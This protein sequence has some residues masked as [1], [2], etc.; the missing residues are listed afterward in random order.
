[1]P[2]PR[3]QLAAIYD[4]AGDAYAGWRRYE[5]LSAALALPALRSASL[6]GKVSSSEVSRPVEAIAES[7]GDWNETCALIA[8]GLGILREITRRM[9]A[10]KGKTTDVKSE[11]RAARCDGVVGED[12]TCTN[13]AVRW[14]SGDN[15]EKHA[16]CWTCIS[17]ARRREEE[18]EQAS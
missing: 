6:D 2:D 14:P 12:P 8:E 17:R 11:V 5:E 16:S 9:T 10:A 1:M 4:L 18:G 15:G 3:N 7:H 13:L